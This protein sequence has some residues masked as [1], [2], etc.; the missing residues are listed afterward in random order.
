MFKTIIRVSSE[1]PDLMQAYLSSYADLLHD[2]WHQSKRYTIRRMFCAVLACMST[3]AFM[4]VSAMAFML[5]LNLPESNWQQLIIPPVVLSV[6]ELLLN[7]DMVKLLDKW[8]NQLFLLN[9]LMIKETIAKTANIKNKI[10]A[11]ST[12]PATMPP[13]PKMAATM[14]MQKKITA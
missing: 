12:A 6:A 3:I 14:A 2:S 11:I 5:S 10:L 1:R 13:K 7:I 9:K 8:M 4:V